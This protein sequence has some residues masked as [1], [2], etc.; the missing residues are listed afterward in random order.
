[1]LNEGLRVSGERPSTVAACTSNSLAEVHSEKAKGGPRR[2][3]IE[4]LIV[5][6]AISRSDSTAPRHRC[7][8]LKDG[9]K[10]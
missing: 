3:S 7:M 4:L 9:V 1:M 8:A 6:W 2:S 5:S 10:I